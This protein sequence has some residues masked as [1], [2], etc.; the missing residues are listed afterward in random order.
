MR[1]IAIIAAYNEERFIAACLE[2]LFR[3]G[4]EAYLIDNC[5]TDETL[6]IARRYIGHGLLG[7]E[8]FPRMDGMYNWRAL[9]TRKEE[10]AATLEADWLMHVDADEVR[11]PPRSHQTLAEAL[12]EIDAQ[13]YNAVDFLEFTFTPTREEPDHDHPDFQST[14]RRYYPFRPWSPHRLTAWRRQPARVELAWY[15]GHRVRFPGLRVCPVLFPMRH[16]LF[17]SVAHFLNK[18]A[19]RIYDHAE[20]KRGWH[21]WRTRLNP[22]LIK[23][24]SQDELRLY[25]S[26]DE[27]D[28]SN[29]RTHDLAEQWADKPRR[30]RW[31]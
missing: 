6:P 3:Q 23:L 19:N 11:L 24:P 21:G 22:A 1:V 17:L 28:P 15:G 25:T 13:G 4:V 31:F 29:P 9:L 2:N 7:I 12:A 8:S 10:L 16:Y 5:S 30:K 14:M 26:D 20:V 27:L 18:Y